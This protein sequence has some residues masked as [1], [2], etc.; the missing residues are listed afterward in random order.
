[1]TKQE[2]NEK[3]APTPEPACC[4][5]TTLETCCATHAK[6]DCCGVETAP[7]VCGCSTKSSAGAAI[8]G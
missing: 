8:S 4:E 6:R 7:K 3:A 5:R 2:S 1:M